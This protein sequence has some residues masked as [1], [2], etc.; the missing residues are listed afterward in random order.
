M[1][2]MV[3]PQHHIATI[4]TDP[5]SGDA[6]SVNLTCT[7]PDDA[8][9]RTY[10]E[11][12]CEWWFR[13][14]T[15]HDAEGHPFVPGRPCWLATWFTGDPEATTYRGPDGWNGEVP[16]VD[17]TGPIYVLSADD[18]YGPQWMFAEDAKEIKQ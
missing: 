4:T 12:D 13:D 16:D 9:C 8:D 1:S 7:A 10:P 15:G 2:S 17:R 18:T 6:I 14:G 3:D 11:C 5:V